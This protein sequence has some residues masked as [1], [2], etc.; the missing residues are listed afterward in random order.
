MWVWTQAL[1]FHSAHKYVRNFLYVQLSATLW[2]SSSKRCP[3]VCCFP[4]ISIII[5]C[6]AHFSPSLPT[7]QFRTAINTFVFRHG[8]TTW[9]SLWR[10]LGCL[11]D[12]FCHNQTVFMGLQE[13]LRLSHI[14]LC[15]TPPSIR[16][17][18]QL[19]WFQEDATLRSLWCRWHRLQ[20]AWWAHWWQLSEEWILTRKV[21]KVPLSLS[22]WLVCYQSPC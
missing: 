22:L 12:S 9:C 14:L 1:L 19:Q 21:S 11:E 3:K 2:M 10:R 13:D 5:V 6:H 18:Q 16:P 20:P 8:Q 4:H 15:S 17:D 7:W